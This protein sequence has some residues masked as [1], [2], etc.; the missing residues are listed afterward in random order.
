VKIE[1]GRPFLCLLIN[2]M[3]HIRKKVAIQI[4][5]A[6]WGGVESFCFNLANS[7]DRRKFEPVFIF[8]DQGSVA[9]RFKNAGFQTLFVDFKSQKDSKKFALI[10]QKN[11]IDLAKTCHFSPFLAMAAQKAGI[12]HILRSGGAILVALPRISFSERKAFLSLLSGLSD[13]IVCPSLFLAQQFMHLRSDVHVIYNGVDFRK[14]NT[15]RVVKKYKYPSVAMP[16]RFI[17]QKRH[18]DFIKAAKFVVKHSPDTRFFCLGELYSARKENREYIAFLKGLVKKLGLNNHI[19]FTGQLNNILMAIS[20]M[21][22]VV[23]PSINEGAS[24]AIIEAMAMGKP[25]VVSD[26]G[27]N[28]EFVVH[29]RTGFMVNSMDP[30]MLG[31]AIISIIY[32]KKKSSDMG[33]AARERAKTLFNIKRC[34]FL[35]EKLYQKILR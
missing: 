12:P 7:L 17:K 15:I 24:N 4:S 32:D 6:I 28:S 16:A 29:G 19:L 13:A 3:S 22:A 5:H 14:V 1:I 9:N 33:Q 18:V 21:D 35:Y 20:A 23:L 34:A 25:V 8:A 26:S 11:R 31:K 30:E 10:L 27:S 2:F